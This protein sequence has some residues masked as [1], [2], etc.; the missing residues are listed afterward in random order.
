MLSC[1]LQ[2]DREKR[3][4]ALLEQTQGSEQA[5]LDSARREAAATG[6]ALQRAKQAR[7]AALAELE[8]LKQAQVICASTGMCLVWKGYYI[9]GRASASP[10]TRPDYQ[11]KTYQASLG[12]TILPKAVVDGV[13]RAGYG[14]HYVMEGSQAGGGRCWRGA[15]VGNHKLRDGAAADQ[16]Q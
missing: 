1:M 10:E 15:A 6:E 7:G 4:K 14:L 5:T 9:P 2:L 3:A 11:G 12:K 16:L 13:L 8:Q